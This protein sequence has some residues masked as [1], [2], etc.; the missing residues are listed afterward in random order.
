MADCAAIAQ[1]VEQLES[2]L[3]N[4][5]EHS[6][7]WDRVLNVACDLE[8]ATQLQ[9]PLVE[10]RRMVLILVISRAYVL[11]KQPGALENIRQTQAT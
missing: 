8:Q 9:P 4:K 6:I 5:D 7:A 10:L 2:M 3:S 1:L 11:L